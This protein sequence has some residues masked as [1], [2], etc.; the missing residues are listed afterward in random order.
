MKKRGSL[1]IIVSVAICV[2]SGGSTFAQELTPDKQNIVTQNCIT[3]QTVL[4]TIQHN[5]TATRVNRGEGYETIISRLMT[6]LNSRSTSQGHNSSASLLISSTDK[7]QQAL[8]SFKDHYQAYDNALSGA[9][10]TKCQQQ[11]QK[12]YDYLE[13]AR[14]QRQVVASDVNNLSGVIGEYRANVLKLK[15]EVR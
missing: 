10:K 13:Q 4:Q 9:L 2:L 12:F 1:G 8:D 14:K 15:E 3:A 11:P 6:P 5:D 7:Y